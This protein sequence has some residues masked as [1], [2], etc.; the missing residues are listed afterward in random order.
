LF[1]TLLREETVTNGKVTVKLLTRTAPMGKT[2]K[3][4]KRMTA[5]EVVMRRPGFLSRNWVSFARV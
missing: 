3:K 5:I 4:S 1:E 2:M